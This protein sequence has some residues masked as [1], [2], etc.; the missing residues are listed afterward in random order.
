MWANQST[1]S[2]PKC[3]KIKALE[4]NHKTSKL[5]QWLSTKVQANQSSDSQPKYKQISAMN[6]NKSAS[7]SKHW[8]S[9]QYMLPKSSFISWHVF[10]INF[11]QN[12]KKMNKVYQTFIHL[13]SDCYELLNADIVFRNRSKHNAL[14]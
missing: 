1:E 11:Q 8:N 4:F 13:L 10:M 3:K 14:S 5:K 6:I 12:K 7:K 9:T 2:Q